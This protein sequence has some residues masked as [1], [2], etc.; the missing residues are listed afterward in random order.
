LLY[1]PPASDGAAAL[2]ERLAAVEAGIRADRHR[3]PAAV[4]EAIARLRAAGATVAVIAA[5]TGVSPSIVR[6]RLRRAGALE[7][8]YRDRHRH[9][10]DM[11]GRRGARMIA[12][13]RA[14]TPI[15]E[16][17]AGAGI[18]EYAVR[19]NLVSRGVVL[20]HTVSKSWKLL[21]ARGA[22]LIATY[23]AGTPIKV[24]AAQ[25]GV[26]RYAMRRFL[27]SKGVALRHDRG[28]PRKRRRAW[29]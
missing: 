22:E 18:S 15:A 26:S 19:N 17:A 16:L 6:D 13:Y 11:P 20:R 10:R 5:E 4:V 25:A 7:Y 29:R 21:N 24:L 2:L 1:C 9:A 28:R 3:Q 27:I 8:R 14:G 23:E 12:S